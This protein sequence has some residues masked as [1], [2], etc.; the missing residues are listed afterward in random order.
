MKAILK[1]KD[2]R[3]KI[4]I[5]LAMLVLFKIGTMITIPTVNLS[6]VTSNNWL[7]MMN[8]LSGSYLGKFTLLSLGLSP[9]ITASIVIQLLGMGVVKP[10]ERWKEEG[11]AG[12]KKTDKATEVLAIFLSI[13]E[14]IILVWTFQNNY[15]VLKS[16]TTLSY[17]ITAGI[18]ILGSILTIIMAKIITKKGIGN[19]SSL[20]IFAGIASRVGYDI[21]WTAKDIININSGVK[22]ALLTIGAFALYM[23]FFLLII[24]LIVF[25]DKSV[26]K[27]KIQYSTQSS[28]FAEK[29]ST[30]PIKVNIAGVI[31]VIF[32]V[33]IMTGITFLGVF[34]KFDFLTKLGNYQNLMGIIFYIFLIMFFTKFYA[35]EIFK[36][37]TIAKNIK[38][39]NAV[40]VG[41]LPGN[42]TEEYLKKIISDMSIVG[43][44]ALAL[45]AL[46]PIITSLITTNLFNLT[47]N[48]TLGGT[49]M[50]IIA[51]VACETVEQIKAKL[52]TVKSTDKKLFD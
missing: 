40:V 37:E 30:I 34:T 18:L 7:T 2:L 50:M 6:G 35:S 46:I 38:K 48:L 3:I 17:V 14:A 36:A 26:K 39:S 25:F 32:T 4:L 51:G 10:F 21:Y 5:T 1:N 44:L 13:I 24:G 42:E 47:L 49:S 19:G 23:L 43:G 52:K 41:K 33:S 9:Y 11:E 12:K 8:Y 29:E 22:T 45:I 15:N 20:I 27:I 31:P 16:S 28:E